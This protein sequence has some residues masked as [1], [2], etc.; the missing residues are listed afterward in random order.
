MLA[1]LGEEIF[2]RGEY[3]KLK[4]K[5]IGPCNILRKYSEKAYELELPVDIG[6]SP[7]FY[8]TN[9]YLYRRNAT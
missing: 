8:A 5:K 6:I 2:R 3:E 7:I 9:L 4:L 1:H